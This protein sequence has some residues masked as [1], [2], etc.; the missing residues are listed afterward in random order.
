MIQYQVLDER[1]RKRGGEEGGNGGGKKG[2]SIQV[3]CAGVREEGEVRERQR[4]VEL[5]T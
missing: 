3:F 2:D 4:R 1:I 5:M